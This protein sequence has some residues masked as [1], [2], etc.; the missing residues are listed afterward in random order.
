MHCMRGSAVRAEESI[1]GHILNRT[2]HR[3]S[4]SLKGLESL[5]AEDLGPSLP[6]LPVDGL[7]PVPPALAVQSRTP[8]PGPKQLDHPPAALWQ[9]GHSS[10]AS[11]PSMS[12]YDYNDVERTPNTSLGIQPW[13]A[14]CSEEL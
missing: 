10:H 1:S 12:Y 14:R 2:K 11:M 6:A 5:G 13:K 3:R 4:L 8:S 7:P 9:D